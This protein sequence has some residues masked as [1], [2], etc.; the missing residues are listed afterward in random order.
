MTSRYATYYHLIM[1]SIRNNLSLYRPDTLA[2]AFA[3]Y[4]VVFWNMCLPF[5]LSGWMICCSDICLSHT[6]RMFK[7]SRMERLAQAEIEICLLLFVTLQT[8]M[9]L[10]CPTLDNRPLV[11]TM[12]WQTQAKRST[13]ILSYQGGNFNL[14]RFICF[15]I[16]TWNE[17]TRLGEVRGGARSISCLSL[18]HCFYSS[19]HARLFLYASTCAFCL[20]HILLQ[21][22]PSTMKARK[23]KAWLRLWAD[24]P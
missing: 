22:G 24:F 1:T 9:S 21:S 17:A 10:L 13:K 23:H 5:W 14:S 16:W 12:G 19:S 6:H 2:H 11:V 18:M 4:T 8:E 7:T 15:M 20:P 3:Y